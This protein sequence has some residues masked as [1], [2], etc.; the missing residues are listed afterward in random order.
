MAWH[1]SGQYMETCNCDYLCPCPISGL[2]RTTHGYCTFAMGFRIDRGQ[3][4]GEALDGLSFVVVGHTPGNMV[5][6]QWKV[7]LIV[8]ERAAP[9]QQEALA[10]IVSGQAGGPMAALGP[11]VGSF[12]GVERHPI[13]FQGEGRSWS[14]LAGKAIDQAVEGASGLG[15]EQLYLDNSGHPANNRLAL[16]AAKKS[17]VHAFGIDWDQEDGRNNGHFAPFEW[18]G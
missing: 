18:R 16:G 6:G 10:A 4:E 11:L 17:H 3:Y 8:D 13:R 15:G 14:V 2:T 9:R 7:G 5:D 1:L 12:L